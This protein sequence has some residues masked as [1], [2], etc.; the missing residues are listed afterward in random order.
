MYISAIIYSSK[1][2]Q[3]RKGIII[4]KKQE[5]LNAL[6]DHILFDSDIPGID[7]DGMK[8]AIMASETRFTATIKEC[9]PD[10]RGRLK[11]G[12][13]ALE[14]QTGIE[15]DEKSR[16]IFQQTLKQYRES[17]AKLEKDAN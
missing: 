2:P 9:V 16:A 7:T 10:D 8:K 11:R 15:P 12:I 6:V 4:M 17:L 3:Q 1:Q 5:F 13:A 14:Y